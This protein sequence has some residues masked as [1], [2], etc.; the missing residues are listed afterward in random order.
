M[1]GRERAGGAKEREQLLAIS[2]LILSESDPCN[3]PA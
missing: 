1:H 2:L 3:S